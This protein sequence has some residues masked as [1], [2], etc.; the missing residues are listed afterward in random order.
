M[1]SASDELLDAQMA[2]MAGGEAA[3][4]A[5]RQAAAESAAAPPPGLSAV[6]LKAW[7]RRQKLLAKEENRMGLLTVAR[8]DVAA[9]ASAE[10]SALT[11]QEPSSSA[12][13]AA[14]APAAVAV[15]APAPVAPAGSTAPA[16]AAV[17]APAAA[18]SGPAVA[19]WEKR[20]AEAAEK[21]E[22]RNIDF[23]SNAVPLDAA[24]SEP[25]SAPASATSEPSD[26]LRQR[27]GAGAAA[28]ATPTGA[29]LSDD[30][31]ETEE[32]VAAV[33]A[34]R[35]RLRVD[36]LRRSEFQARQVAVL[37]LALGAGLWFARHG[38]LVGPAG[39]SLV[40]RRQQQQQAEDA[41]EVSL[42]GS[43]SGAGALEQE[44]DLMLNVLA[45]P[46]MGWLSL[47]LA[48]LLLRWG[49]HVAASTAGGYPRDL[50]ST[51]P[52]VPKA[53][54]GGMM[55]LVAMVPGMARITGAVALLSS[56]RDDVVLF[57]VLFCT[58]A[59]LATLQGGA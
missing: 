18:D 24:P 43:G 44:M 22:V 33:R 39:A 45:P 57:L 14:A 27:A 10:V 20:W 12:A 37:A 38:G 13:A 53:E 59:A 34:L 47:P 5:V 48:L 54:G 46:L 41:A 36:R 56:V 7:Q 52:P 17:P 42:D 4:S 1:A 49:L 9:A 58:S 55:G 6:Q 28:A 40:K 23:V 8:D 25:G 50:Q 3:R 15:A 29:K 21:E 11:E 31:V 32:S 35:E 26:G 2:R 30:A 51:V 19:K 16:A